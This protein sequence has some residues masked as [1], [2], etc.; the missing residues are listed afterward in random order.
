MTRQITT[1]CCSAKAIMRHP[2]FAVG[3]DD[4]RARR[5]FN[6]DLD[7]AYWAYERGRLLG[8]IMPQSMSLYVARGKL[9]PQAVALFEAAF[10]KRLV[11]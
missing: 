4:V 7:D 10:E 1:S 9:N 8:M 6:C 2:N 3:V 11:I 5:S